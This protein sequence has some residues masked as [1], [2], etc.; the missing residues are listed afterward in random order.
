MGPPGLFGDRENGYFFSGIWGASSKLL[1]F[2]EPCKKEEIHFQ[3]IT[4]NE[5]HP[6]HL[7][8]KKISSGYGGLP[9]TPPPPKDVN[10]FTFVLTCS[11]AFILEKGM[12]NNVYYCRFIILKDLLV[13][14]LIITYFGTLRM[15]QMSAL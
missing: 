7:I 12:P 14:R 9:Q 5:K 11:P 15:R 6:F 3:N 8:V 2:M 1:G 13:F 10:V 4:L